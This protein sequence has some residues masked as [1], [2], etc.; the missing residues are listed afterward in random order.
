MRKYVIP[1]EEIT[2]SKGNV[3]MRKIKRIMANARIREIEKNLVNLLNE[4]YGDDAD[5]EI[6]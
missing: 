5:N 4:T 3:I 6:A 2:S 1:R